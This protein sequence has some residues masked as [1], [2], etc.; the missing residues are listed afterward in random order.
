MDTDA[1]L[2]NLQRTETRLLELLDQRGSLEDILAVERELARVRGEIESSTSQMKQLRERVSLA[3]CHVTLR[4]KDREIVHEPDDMWQP[5]RELARNIGPM[6]GQSFAAVVV[7]GAGL[8]GL[9]IYAL[10]WLL[11]LTGAL[12]IFRRPR[13]WILSKLGRKSA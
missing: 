13:R 8:V 10:P 6:F 11:L 5:V 3:T 7:V 2:R 9:F 4:E 1:R 12:M